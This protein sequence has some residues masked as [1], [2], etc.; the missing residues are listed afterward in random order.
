MSTPTLKTK[1]VL[2]KAGGSERVNQGGTYVSC[3]LLTGGNVGDIQLRWD[4]GAT[5][6][7]DAGIG[8]LLQPKDRF[9]GFYLENSGASDITVKYQVGDGEVRLAGNVTILGTVT[10]N[11]SRSTTIPTTPDYAPAGAGTAVAVALNAIR[12]SVIITADPLNTL[13]ARF[14][15]LNTGA[16]RGA[17]LA[18]GQTIVIDSTAAVYIY[19][20]GAGQKFSITEVCD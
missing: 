7:F 14:G 11:P 20:S 6:D 16:A 2:V 12:R 8:Y 3:K 1:Q 15:D 17:Q 5:N 13:V 18:P 4:N 9:E 19:V 10:V